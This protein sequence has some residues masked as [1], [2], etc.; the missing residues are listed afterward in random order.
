METRQVDRQFPG[1]VSRNI[2]RAGVAVAGRN[3][4]D[5]A[6]LLE[7]AI[8]KI[9]TSGNAFFETG[10]VTQLQCGPLLRKSDNI[11]DA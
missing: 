8:Q 5:D 7:Y 3:A 2:N 10:R 1:Q 6:I 11:F 9:G 4:I